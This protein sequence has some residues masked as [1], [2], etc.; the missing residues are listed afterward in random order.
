M[1]WSVLVSIDEAL[2]EYISVIIFQLAKHFL[3]LSTA[4]LSLLGLVS[5]NTTDL[6]KGNDSIL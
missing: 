1:L 5:R 2:L 6:L 4:I 3:P